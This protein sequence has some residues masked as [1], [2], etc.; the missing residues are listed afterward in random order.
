MWNTLSTNLRR[1]DAPT[2]RQATF[3][4]TPSRSDALL[5]TR[6]EQNGESAAEGDNSTLVPPG[7]YLEY[8]YPDEETPQSQH[9]ERRVF[10]AATI[11]YMV[12]I[13][14]IIL[15]IFLSGYLFGTSQQWW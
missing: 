13:L 11:L 3:R 1:H 2:G 5:E 9:L 6:A 7:L 10:E 15:T 12:L 14:T 4:A 8:G